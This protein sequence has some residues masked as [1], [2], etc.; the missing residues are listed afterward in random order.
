MTGDARKEAVEACRQW[1]RVRESVIENAERIDGAEHVHEFDRQM[2]RL[3]EQ[4]FTSEGEVTNVERL[5]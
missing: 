1:A 5:T 3:G 4:V 2:F